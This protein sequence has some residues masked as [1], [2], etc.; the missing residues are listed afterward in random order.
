[1]AG[2]LAELDLQFGSDPASDQHHYQTIASNLVD[3]VH[4]LRRYLAPRRERAIEV[5]GHHLEKRHNSS[6]IFCP[7]RL[8]G[9][10]SLQ[11]LHRSCSRSLGTCHPG[12]LQ[13][14]GTPQ[15]PT[16]PPAQLPIKPLGR[17]A[18]RIAE[19][20]WQSSSES[21]KRFHPSCRGAD[22]HHPLLRAALHGR[23]S[24]NPSWA[25]LGTPDG[26]CRSGSRRRSPAPPRPPVY[27]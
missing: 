16:K 4:R 23:H 22:C 2:D 8:G 3:R 24:V 7:R 11:P 27:R 20:A 12:S 14:S 13:C 1:M 9:G 10:I 21:D 26:T 15:L 5:D 17:P 19:I 25:W 18:D 6:L